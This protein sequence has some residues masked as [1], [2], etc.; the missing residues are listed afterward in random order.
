MRNLDTIHFDAQIKIAGD[1][2]ESAGAVAVKIPK[3]L[4][5]VQDGTV[6]YLR[7]G[8]SLATA[9]QVSFFFG[10]PLSLLVI[11]VLVFFCSIIN[12]TNAG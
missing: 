6:W 9:P 5:Q 4:P 8:T 10:V 2:P 12:W 11:V 1:I 3:D 7:L